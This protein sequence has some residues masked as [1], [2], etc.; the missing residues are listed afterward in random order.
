[1]DAIEQNKENA[2]GRNTWLFHH[3]HCF[4]GSDF[5]SRTEYELV[6][7]D[8]DA[9]DAAS[10]TQYLDSNKIEYKL[11]ANGTTISVP[12]ANAAKVRWMLVRKDW[13]RTVP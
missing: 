8:L 3:Q 5:F 1:M 12:A 9:A 6:F 2:V 11:G 13:S 4:A 7:Q 10:I